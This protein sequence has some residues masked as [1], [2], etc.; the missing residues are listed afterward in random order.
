MTLTAPPPVQ[1]RRPAWPYSI[2]RAPDGSVERDLTPIRIRQIVESGEGSL[3]VDVDS[4]DRHQHACLEKLFGFHHLA[5]EDTLSP[6]TRVK[7][8]EYDRHIFVVIACLTFD[9]TTPDPFDLTTTNLYFF[10]GRNYLVTVHSRALRPISVV[11]ER[12]TRSPDLL[13]RGPGMTM[14][15]LIDTAVDLYFPLVEHVDCLVDEMEQ[16]LFEEFDQQVIKQ[17]FQAKRMTVDLRRRMGP[18]REVLN[19]L[20]NRPCGFLAPASQLYYRDV[21][22]H[23]IRIVESVDNTRDILSSVLDTYLSQ[24]SNR[25]NQVMKE[26]SIVSTIALPIVAISGVFGM[27]IHSLPFMETRWGW[28][29]VVGVMAAVSGVML[30]TLRKN[31]WL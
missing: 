10:L 30:W 3:W 28:A 22:D 19:I 13:T 12:F 24:V 5:V 21:Y 18:L 25:M 4:S 1:T 2:Y 6:D 17:V 8:E 11:Q 26:L 15:A 7:M 31:R 9:E 23:T 27:N 29:V 16:R 20:T 14:H